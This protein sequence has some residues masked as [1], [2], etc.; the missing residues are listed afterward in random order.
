MS[1]AVSVTVVLTA[2]GFGETVV[3]ASVVEVSDAEAAVRKLATSMEPRPVAS[4]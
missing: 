1:V 2:T 4:L 3:S